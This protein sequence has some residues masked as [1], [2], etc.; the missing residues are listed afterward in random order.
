MFGD[1]K[2]IKMPEQ[3]TAKKITIDLSP[4]IPALPRIAD[5]TK[6]D[7][8][9]IL[10]SPYVS[11][12]IF[13]NKKTSELVYE[14]E[15]PVLNEEEKTLLRRIE[16]G[17]KEIINVN[18]LV[19]RTQEAMIEYLDKTARFLITE[20][21]LKV[22]E[23]AYKKIFYYLFRDFVG[24]NEIEPL[25]R[26]Y[27][28]EDIECNGVD[29]PVYIVHR[30]YRNLKTNIRYKSI[31][32][33]ASFTEK[34]S[35]RCGK[36]ISYAS[37]LLDGS[38]PDG[39][40][41][42]ATYTKDITSKGPTFTIRKFTKIPWTPVQLIALNTLSPEILAY[43]WILIQY[44]SNILITGGTA[45]GKTTLL[46]AVAFFIPP[47]SRVVSI[48]DSVTG[49]SEIII[50]ERK[51]IRKITIKEFVDKKIDAEVLTVDEKGK[52]IFVKPSDYLKHKVKKDI[53]EI[54]TATGRKLKV[55]Q[56]HSLFTLG[57]T[58][59]EEIKPTQLKEKKSFIAV[60]RILPIPGTQRNKI[61]LIDNLKIFK[62][63][64]LCGEPLKKFFE[65]HKL[66]D[67]DVEK[68]RYRWWKKN[69]LIKIEEF[70]KK[71]WKFSKDELIRLKIKSKNKSS[72]PV[73]FKVD[74]EFLEFCGLW[75]GDG[76]YDNY[77]KNSVIVSNCDEECR[78]VVKS[79]ANYLGS[80]FSL[81]N[82][83]GVSIRIHSSV[84]YKFMKYFLGFD[85]YSS[86]KKIPDFIFNLSNEQIRDF[87]RGYFSADGCI[88]K[89]EA[90]CAS[91]SYQLLSDLQTL[92]LRLGII[93][94]INDFDRKDKCINMS[95]SEA[96]NIEK[97]KE[98][99]FLQER[100]NEKLNTMVKK[101]HHTFSDVVPLSINQLRKVNEHFKISWPYLQGMQNIGRDYLQKIAT[102][103][104]FFNDISHSDILW[105]RVK[106]IKKISSEEIEVF[107]LSIPGHERFICN[108]IFVHNTRE[109]NLSR[110]NWLPSVARTAI[111]VG[112]IGEVDLFSLLK[113][114]FR[115]NPDY[116]IVGEV[117]GK[118][119]FVL[120]QGM[121]SG[122]A[123]LSTLHA[124]SVDTVI[125]R[126][127]TPP[128]ELS[129]T[130]VNTLDS[131]CIMT[132]A[133]VKKQQTRRLREVVEI[134]NVNPDGIAL[135]NT[136]FTWNPKDDRFYF[137]K[138]SRV[139]DKIAGRYGLTKEELSEEFSRRSK[140]LYAM[141]KKKI[142]GFDDVQ[143]IINNYYKNPEATL[144]S[145]GL[146]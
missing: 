31:D 82:D 12:H 132:H 54:T 46:N 120:F 142:F 49:D 45:S 129:P 36:Y 145:L 19:E 123:S 37:P 75:L 87:I 18:V 39:S 40:R 72:V 58:G 7:I 20:L 89:S 118:E 74:K 6:I 51:R 67:F 138:D 130:L 144:K 33:L 44:K 77:N 140:I 22:S 85:G 14:L 5:K 55:T 4:A 71:D 141:Y 119:A 86:S 64:F 15:E 53:Y 106:K 136:P 21:D 2:E 30:L 65:K 78:K 113:N 146:S 68:E 17:M 60:P 98:I 26:D 47:E 116:L 117:R 114:S 80:N 83:G 3:E 23:S 50:K 70:L 76:S 56:D 66:K 35:Q 16:E 122:H 127:E 105:D 104:S 1:K 34:L 102:P 25:I 100:K 29:T 24:L 128:I 95:I 62:T 61:N 57:E 111:G 135:T 38:L 43:L 94:R 131:V 8:R 107:D 41:V 125:K 97:F 13:F 103:N 99:R 59:L 91:Q 134:V 48:E 69:N 84:F 108:N 90:S 92:F 126:L 115:Q 133:I 88:K 137:K 28:I 32:Y 73:L 96:K 63:D 121:A 93:S 139:F 143:K 112:K 124:D 27:F 101:A 110:E 11:A 42:N 52:I 9:Y 10:I 81:M 109:L 79:I